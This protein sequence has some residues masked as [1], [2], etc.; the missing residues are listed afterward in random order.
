MRILEDQE[1]VLALTYQQDLLAIKVDWRLGLVTRGYDKLSMIGQADVVSLISKF[2]KEFPIVNNPFYLKALLL[3]YTT[4][5]SS[6]TSI[7][8]D[9]Q[10]LISSPCSQMFYPKFYPPFLLLNHLLLHYPLQN[11]PLF[12]HLNW[13]LYHPPCPHLNHLLHHPLYPH[14]HLSPHLNY[15]WYHPPCPHLNHLLHY[16]LYP[17]IN[18]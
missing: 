12:P 17:H 2:S 16:P 7:T 1:I 8:N 18:Y 5:T 9:L 15:L 6:I 13:L 10:S 3:I 11:N 4:T 14:H